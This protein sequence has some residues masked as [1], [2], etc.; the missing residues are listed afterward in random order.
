MHP[1][2]VRKAL[3]IPRSPRRKNSAD[4]AQTALIFPD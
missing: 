1:D 2:L 3:T 4:P